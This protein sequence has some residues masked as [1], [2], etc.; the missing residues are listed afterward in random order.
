MVFRGDN[1]AAWLGLA[2]V[3][4]TI[5]AS[6][7]N[8]QLFYFTPGWIYVFGVGV[9]AGMLLGGK[10]LIAQPAW[11][12][13]TGWRRNQNAVNEETKRVASAGAE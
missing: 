5:V 2:V 9:L 6:L 4:Q 11:I 1:L 10:S 8:S 12:A 7:F 3:V 13:T